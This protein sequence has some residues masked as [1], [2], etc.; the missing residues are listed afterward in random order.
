M[1]NP[2]FILVTLCLFSVTFLTGCFQNELQEDENIYVGSW[3]NEKF[4]LEIWSNGYARWQ[5]INFGEANEGNVKIEDG[6]IKFRSGAVR[7]RQF[8]IDAPPAQQANGDVIMVLDGSEFLK[9]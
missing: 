6:K 9:H 1:K 2:F 7:Y 8:T 5:R 3:G 4:M